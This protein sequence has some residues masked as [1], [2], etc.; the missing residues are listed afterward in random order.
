MSRSP[1]RSV[2]RQEL[3]R[4]LVEGRCAYCRARATPEQ[5][6]TREH[7]IPR[8]RGGG[9]H[10]H[11]IIVPACARCNQR[12]GCQELT[13]FLLTHPRRIS[14]LLDYLASLPPETLQQLDPRVFA[15]LY[16][17]LWV[18]DECTAL[19]AAW[20]Q[21][22]RRLC[23]GRTIHRRRYAARRLMASAGERL[24][25]RRA[26][27][28]AGGPSCLLPPGA[29]TVTRIGL[30]EPLEATRARLTSLLSLLWNT[31]AEEVE[32]TL[33]LV[34]ASALRATRP[35]EDGHD[36]PAEDAHR[37]VRGRG[38]RRLR[39]DRRRGGRLP[40]RRAA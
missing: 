31:P 12:R 10:D 40:Q 36:D 26:G 24:R 23:G 29:A 16:A 1:S 35:H 7:L 4:H 11:R 21:Q 5:P 39:T 9:R 14:A 37:T 18:L 15:E 38:A 17:A 34:H 20:R 25:Q 30:D 33:W 19:G 3:E 13:L 8:S 32:T 28:R 22:L 6:L 27:G 2:L